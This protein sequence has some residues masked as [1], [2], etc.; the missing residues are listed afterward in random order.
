MADLPRIL[1]ILGAGS[2]ADFG[3]PT[4]RSIFKNPEAQ[5]YLGKDK[6]LHKWLQKVFWEP[7]GHS[8]A[9]SERSVTIEEM[10]TIM[11]DWQGE[12]KEAPNS[13]EFHEMRR[14]LFVLIYQAVYQNKSSDKGHLNGLIDALGRNF[15]TV[16]WASFNWDCIFEAS[17]WYNSGPPMMYSR[18]NPGIVIKLE[19]WRGGSSRHEYLKL[20]GSVNWWLVKGKTTYLKWASHGELTEKWREYSEQKTEDE[21]IILEPS[22]YKYDHM[23]FK[24][25]LQPQWQHFFERLCQA[26]C[27]LILGYSLPEND[28]QARCKIL[29]AFQ[30][31]TGC[32]WAIVDPTN[33]TRQ[34]YERLL[35]SKKLRT[36]DTSLAGF[37]VNLEDNLKSAFPDIEIK[38]KPI[39]AVSAAPASGGPAKVETTPAKAS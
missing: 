38:P 39:K 7:R 23:L 35:G 36:F 3:V 19:G 4:L 24:E 37:G 10:L 5:A 34:K 15:S 9:T 29:T 12:A 28:P 14:R 22:A 11:R 17:Y 25:I 32:R 16:T 2:S 30:V 20:H 18:H 31:N 27:V 6:E 21:P 8:L 33:E 1:I 13:D 26:D